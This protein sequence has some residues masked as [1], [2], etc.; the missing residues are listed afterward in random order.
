[1]A[2]HLFNLPDWPPPVGS[3]LSITARRSIL[4]LAII[5]LLQPLDRFCERSSAQSPV[6]Q[7]REVTAGVPVKGELRA[8]DSHLFKL[9][10]SPRQYVKVTIQKKDFHLSASILS[11]DQQI[12]SEHAS[13]RF[14][15]LSFAFISEPGGTAYLRLS[16]LEKEAEP[17]SYELKL[18]EVREATTEDRNLVVAENL[19]SE[20]EAL[21]A[22]WDQ[23]SL[24]AAIAKYSEALAAFTSVGNQKAQVQTLRDIG[25]CHFILSEYA[26]ALEAFTRA[27]S[28]SQQIKDKATS[29]DARNDVGYVHVYL[30]E[31]SKALRYFVQVLSSVTARRQK[32]QALNNAGEVY[33]SL[34]EYAKAR[35]YFKRALDEWTA[36]SDRMGQALAHLN[37]GYTYT[38]L[39]DLQ[40]ASEHYHAA[41][42]FWQA[43]GYAQGEALSLT[44]LGGL[45]TFLGEKQSALDNHRKAMNIFQVI[46]SYQ[47]QAQAMNG[48]GQVYEDSNELHAALDSYRN[49]LELYRRIGNRDFMALSQYYV[50]RVYQ[51]LDETDRA[52]EDYLQSVELSRQVGDQTVEAQILRGIGMAY[53]TAGKRDEALAQYEASLKLHQRINDRRGQA[54]TLNSIGHVY[55]VIGDK[56]KA[57]R[58]YT[59]ALTL[60]RAVADRREEVLT[61]YNLAHA[62]RDR[63]N[64][65]QAI[66]HITS[67]VDLIESMRLKIAGEQLRT[68][69]FASVH[70]HYELLIDLLMR[71]HKNR[72]NEGF[73]AAALQASERAR[74]RS[75]L[76]TLSVSE[77]KTKQQRN[78]ELLARERSL[79]Q[80]LA[81]KLESRARLLNDSRARAEAGNTSEIR[82]LMADFQ[83]VLNQIKQ[84]SPI[85]ASFTQAQLFR[86]EDVHTLAREDT[87][88]LQYALGEEQSYLWA[89]TPDGSIMSFELPPRATIEDSAGKVYDLLVARQPRENEDPGDYRRRIES[90][91]ASYWSRASELSNLLL[92]KVAQMIAGK[93]LLIVCDGALHRIPFDAL[94]EPGEA[95]GEG[96]VTDS[97]HIRPLVLEHEVVTIPSFSVLAALERHESTEASASRLVAVLADPVFNHSDVRVSQLGRSMSAEPSTPPEMALEASLRDVRE[98]DSEISLPRLSS[99][100]KEVE[101]ITELIPSRDRLIATGFDANLE[102]V[103]EGSLRDFRIIHFATHGRFNDEQPELSGLIL[104]RWDKSGKQVN[105]LLRLD[106]IYKL[107]LNADLVVLSACR[108]GLGHQVNGEGILG[109]TRGFM[110]AGSRSVIASLWKVNDMATAELMRYFYQAMLKDGLP[111]SAALRAAKVKMWQQRRWRSPYFWAAFVMQGKYDR[112]PVVVTHT[113]SH[114]S[115]AV[116]ISAAIFL[117]GLGSFLTFHFMRR[118]SWQ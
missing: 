101:V 95:F 104:S 68:S 29:L 38:D 31:N 118:R 32:A 21:R 60:S 69:Y 91:D 58:H 77:V 112:S 11:P 54:R 81:F 15:A 34:S 36:E 79:W 23:E 109:I 76:E 43:V 114:N 107:D 20:A 89:V 82:K 59:Q 110:Y 108:T 6:E 42:T 62:E 96:T 117:L 1:M 48:M 8:K 63:G 97:E 102:T 22:K 55:D 51:K 5:V 111:P 9:A 98:G 40:N 78:K 52:L 33:Y 41:L 27:L 2:T 17:R 47:G 26:P 72:P 80:Q 56:P 30:G 50:G 14:G 93:R 7:A 66:A 105:G 90:A 45:D 115:S 19:Y 53:E 12:Q 100:R 16:S 106:D 87:V 94:P 99:S 83:E 113:Q 25:E 116:M 84:E 18:D 61:L 67:A 10:V 85:Y 37:L 44:A 88:L 65:D 57:I 46:G 35:D 75:L 39:G 103:K 24:R 70:Q 49:A 86:A 74:A 73:D 13:R 4:A 64:L 92:G 3:R 28:L 71:A